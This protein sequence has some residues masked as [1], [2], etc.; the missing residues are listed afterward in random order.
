MA[1]RYDFTAQTI[2]IIYDRAG[3]R[4][5]YEDC[6]D[7]TKGPTETTEGSEKSFS[8]GVAAHIY[9]AAP[10]GPRPRGNRSAE[11]I[12]NAKNGMWM[13]GKHGSLI[14]SASN[15][16]PAKR[17]FQMKQV[18]ET[19]QLIVTSYPDVSY[20]Q[21]IAGVKYLQTLI[22]RDFQNLEL[23]DIVNEYLDFAT[24][25]A[26]SARNY[27]AQRSNRSIPVPFDQKQLSKAVELNSI[28]TNSSEGE[29]FPITQ[30][31]ISYSE[32]YNSVEKLIFKYYKCVAEVTI[33]EDFI[34]V[35]AASKESKIQTNYRHT[36]QARATIFIDSK[37]LSIF[38]RSELFTCNIDVDLINNENNSIKLNEKRIQKLDLWR[39]KIDENI[40]QELE[41]TLKVL[42]MLNKGFEP[43]L[44]ICTESKLPICNPVVANW[45]HTPERLQAYIEMIKININRIKSL[46][47]L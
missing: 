31:A 12:K 16:F 24:Y 43:S 9:S 19:A 21:D 41:C 42:E 18:R 36:L 23:D 6:A 10:S 39:S 26:S 38:A 47:S 46:Y 5:S 3:G 37:R 35:L 14:D 45:S 29:P 11:E 20:Y 25:M 28:D 34:L 40:Y 27:H 15:E 4:C 1:N 7:P 13:C 30:K 33:S 32:I 44:T 22:K 17:L 8:I 2:R